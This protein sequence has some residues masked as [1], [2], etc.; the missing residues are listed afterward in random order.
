MTR[1][2]IALLLG[3]VSSA[4]LSL[5]KPKPEPVAPLSAKGQ[6]L[7]K[8]YAAQM[9]SLKTDL[10]KALSKFDASKKTA[11]RKALEAESAARSRFNA[12]QQATGGIKK[13]E[14]AVSHAKNKW[15]RGA[16]KGIA[17]A[18]KKLKAAKNN[19]QRKAAEKEIAKWQ[20]NREDGMKALKQ[21]EAALEMAKRVEKEGPKMIKAAQKELAQVKDKTHQVFKQIGLASLL[22][23]GALDAKLTQ[24][25]VLLDATPRGL[26]EYAQRGSQQEQWVKQLLSDIDLMRQMLVADGAATQS[27]GR[28][29][30]PAQFGPAMEIYTKI[31]KQS[32]AAK[33]GVLQQ[34]ALAIA[35]EHA[36]PISQRNPEE[37]AANASAVVDPVKRFMH[38]SK[39][40]Q[41]GE[42]DPAFKLLNAWDMRMVVDGSE[43]DETISWG[44]LMLRNFQPGHIDGQGY[45]WRYVRIVATDVKYGSGDVQYDRPELQFFQN[46]I[47]NGGVCGRRAFFGRFALRS[48]G[49]PTIA[50]PSR[51]HAS[52]AHW[53]P[54]GWVIN[55]GPGWGGGW[56]KGVYNKDR[57][58]LASTQARF[59]EKAYLQV[60]RS[61]W[62]GDVMGEERVYGEVDQGTPAFWYALALQLQ[63]SIIEDSKA[64]TLAALGTDLGESNNALKDGG[65]ASSSS[66]TEA[67]RKINVSSSGT[68]SIP[69]AAYNKSS[70][71]RGFRTVKS[72]GSG[73]QL[74][75]P[76]FAPEGVTVL[77]GGN[78]KSGVEDCSSGFRLKSGGYG[79]YDNWGFRAAMT[80]PAGAKTPQE[81]KLNLGNGVDMEFVY[82][83]PGS[84][85]MGGK[86][87]K[88]GRFTC[89]EVPKHD[90]TI[91]K[92]FY[93]AKYE[94]TQAQYEVIMGRNPSKS[95]KGPNYPVDT[96]PEADASKFCELASG[97]TEQ[98]IRLPF[99]AE[100]EYA[101]RAG[102]NTTY[103]F[104]DSV[105][106]LADYA[107][108]KD[109]AG[110]KSQQ[111][112]QKKPNP[113]GLYDIYGNVVERCADRYKADYYA[114]SPKKDPTGPDLK[115]QSLVQYEFN[116]PR[117]G[118]YALSAKVVTN[119]YNQHLIA[120]TNGS[121]K[122]TVTLPFTLGDWQDSKPVMVD[123]QKGKNT[124]QIHRLNPPQYGIAVKSFTLTPVK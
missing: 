33:S 105:A 24:Y 39:A 2:S 47:M 59:N 19:G 57:N 107:W 62:L 124:L 120:T 20:K 76:R 55:L 22:E 18:Q 5:A 68:I 111:V 87:T 99:E 53:T 31:Q 82:I 14:G 60:K 13:A 102:K 49:I 116:A 112:G 52:L 26:A 42:L 69:S 64:E 41:A 97:I 79:R 104:G 44:R 6:Q 115:K 16:D 61:Q 88:D 48:F 25:V 85:V 35:L 66:I 3:I 46:I 32:P 70:N 9:Q 91:T 110:G 121:N 21:R 101:A 71:K 29:R 122:T 119:N 58:F 12:A 38:F 77:R 86:N 94:V 51:G 95:T 43:P 4:S 81:V 11:Y 10:Q 27:K 1:I 15:I 109:N 72:H 50:R 80:S 114:N 108:F 7:E 40:Y 63:R 65:D 54:K 92:G 78:W 56:T 74:Y 17:K 98:A 45:G 73:M 117:S 36:V 83:K 96:I 123:L 100:W 103:F 8:A 75:M 37:A 89:V 30:G 106:P 113:W 34:L 93:L 90:V 84:F 118:R 28:A 67:Y 23:G